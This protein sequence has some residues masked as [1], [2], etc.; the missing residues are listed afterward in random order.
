MVIFKVQF[1]RWPIV[2][3]KHEFVDV[4]RRGSNAAVVPIALHHTLA[5][6]RLEIFI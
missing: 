2:C 5:N 1:R 3:I 4:S 6:Q